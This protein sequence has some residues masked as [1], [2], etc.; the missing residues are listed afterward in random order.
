MNNCEAP[1]KTVAVTVAVTVLLLVVPLVIYIMA[2]HRRI[3]PYVAI[4]KSFSGGGLPAAALAAQGFIP[5]LKQDI[6]R[7]V[8]AMKRARNY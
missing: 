6:S 7:A 1:A 5:E 3:A 4:S 2:M 8:Q